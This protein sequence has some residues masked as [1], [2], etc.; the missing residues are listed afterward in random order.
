MSDLRITE[1]AAG[2]V[3][4]FILSGALVYDEGTRMLREVLTKAVASGARACLLDLEHITYLDSCGVGS[5]VEMFRHVTGRGGQLKLL[6]PSACARQVLGVTHL[7]GV[8][9]I[10][11]DESEALLNLGGSAATQGSRH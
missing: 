2:R 1:R 10:F 4:I 9:D 8:F 5:L 3:T 6:R 7:T 11:D